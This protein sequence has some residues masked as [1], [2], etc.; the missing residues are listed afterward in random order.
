MND[1]DR[2]KIIIETLKKTT[3][4]HTAVMIMNEKVQNHDDTLYGN[5]Q[6]GSVK[7]ITILQ[8]RQENCPARQAATVGGKRLGIAYVMMVIGIIS[9]IMSILIALRGV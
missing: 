3:E 5:G 2:D 4:T 7:D 1:N 9:V 8:E 6:Q